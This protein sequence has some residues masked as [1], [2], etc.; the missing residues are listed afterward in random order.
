VQGIL[1]V[2]DEIANSTEVLLSLWKH[3]CQRVI[4]DRFT[5]MPD[6]Q[7][8]DENLDKVRNLVNNVVK[9]YLRH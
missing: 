1:L 9:L 7:W 8:F 6:K 5:N 2:D 3:E 4:A